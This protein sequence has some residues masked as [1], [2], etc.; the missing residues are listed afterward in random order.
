MNVQ[1]AVHD[2]NVYVIEVNPRASRTVP[3]AGKATGVLLAQIATFCML[4]KTL[5]ECG[6]T[7]EVKV[8]HFAIKEAVLPFIKF[9]GADVILSPEMR[10]T[11]EVMGIDHSRKLAHIKSQIAAGN[12][13]PETGNIFISVRDS[14]KQDTI[15]FAQSLFNMGFKIYATLGTSTSLYDEGVPTTAVFRISQGRPNIIDLLKLGEIHWIMTT[16]EGGKDSFED[17]MLMRTWAIRLGI[18]I[19]TTVAGFKA[20]VEGINEKK[21]FGH[22]EVCPIQDYHRH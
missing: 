4:G 9:P 11:G 20:A 15:K 10:S 2:G 22:F 6:F 3:F 7:E 21:S 18:P 8:R 1:L 19:T 16:A 12:S 5:S 13:L 14:D 17:E